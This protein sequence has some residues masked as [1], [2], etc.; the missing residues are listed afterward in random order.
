MTFQ[1]IDKSFPLMGNNTN[2]KVTH[3]QFQ[4]TPFA[5]KERGGGDKSEAV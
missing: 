1:Y 2:L 4:T 5:L 3:I